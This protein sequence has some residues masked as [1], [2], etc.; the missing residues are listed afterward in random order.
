[1]SVEIEVEELRRLARRA[2]Y[3]PVQARLLAVVA[4]KRG[5][6]TQ[7]QIAESLERSHRAVQ[8]WIARF[9]R[10]G[11]EALWD[12]PRSGQPP[13]LAREREEEF[14][15]R[16]LE[17]PGEGRVWRA[18]DLRNLLREEFGAE[19]RPKSVYDLLHRLGLSWL[20][21][22]PRHPKNDPEAMERWKKEE[23]P[24]LSGRR[25]RSTPARE[26]RSGPRTRRG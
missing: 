1:M 18:A 15:R 13:K 20:C 22:R 19:Y 10:G 12:R 7:K 2:A 11:V 8:G 3:A 14:K 16:V 6:K 17:G 4:W 23:A 25:A 24:L 9:K 26:S 21:P 5:G